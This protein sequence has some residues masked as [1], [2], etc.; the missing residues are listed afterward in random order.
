MRD[1]KDM[2]ELRSPEGE[3][4]IKEEMEA[5]ARVLRWMNVPINTQSDLFPD[6]DRRPITEK[7]FGEGKRAGIAGAPHV[8]PYHPTNDG[9][10]AWNDG[11]IAG[12]DVNLAKIKPLD[13]EDAADS[14][15][16]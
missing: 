10:K 1:I 7:A 6:V 12:Q 9:H 5:R 13:A 14:L 3:G 15:A 8:N 2:I 4:R 16:N 11:Y